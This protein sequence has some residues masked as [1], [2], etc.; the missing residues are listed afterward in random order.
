MEQ[1]SININ[2]PI[3]TPNELGKYPS[4]QVLTQVPWMESSNGGLPWTRWD[5]SRHEVQSLSDGPLQV[6]QLL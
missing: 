1:P 5:A 3:Q 2:L 4:K 6:R